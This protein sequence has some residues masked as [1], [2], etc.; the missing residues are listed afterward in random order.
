MSITRDEDLDVYRKSFEVVP[1]VHDWTRRF[2]QELS[3]TA[4]QF[5]FHRQGLRHDAPTAHQRDPGARLIRRRGF[6][7][8]LRSPVSGLRYSDYKWALIISLSRWVSMFDP[9]ITTQ[10]RLKPAGISP[11]RIAAGPTAAEPSI[12][13]R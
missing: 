7:P 4:A 11:S 6:L 9:V 12:A 5:A 13:T 2:P 1:S 8:G 3:R 10:T